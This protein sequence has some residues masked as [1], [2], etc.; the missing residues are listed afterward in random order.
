MY[1][2]PDK[3]LVVEDLK[4]KRR[5]R[6]LMMI[7]CLL[8]VAIIVLTSVITRS[9]ESNNNNNEQTGDGNGVAS[10]EGSEFEKSPQTP[11]VAPAPTAIGG[12]I[13]EPTTQ[14]PSPAVT[15]SEPTISP[16]TT[17][18]AMSVLAPVVRD[19][20][21]LGNPATSEGR[22]YAIVSSEGL[23]D[24][25]KVIQRYSLLSLYFASDGEDWVSNN[26]WEAHT[27]DECS[28][29]GIG[30]QNGVVKDLALCKLAHVS[31]ISC[32]FDILTRF[33]HLPMHFLLFSSTQLT[34]TWYVI[35]TALFSDRH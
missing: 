4:R 35:Q 14:A 34:T 12:W 33:P 5:R 30:C 6:V 21:R 9:D 26:G 19:P 15:T 16:T 24:R 29:Y 27:S 10:V 11:T 28:W 18:F 13:D 17:S 31:L 7:A 23:D 32:L 2:D 8:L 20:T 22:A 3:P 1:N 25:I